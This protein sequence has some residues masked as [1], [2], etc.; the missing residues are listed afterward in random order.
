MRGIPEVN[1]ASNIE[2][3]NNIL[4]TFAN[5][6]D[7]FCAY[8]LAYY[9]GED[10]INKMDRNE[11]DLDKLTIEVDKYILLYERAAN[12]GSIEAM[13]YLSDLY[14]NPDMFLVYELKQKYRNAVK[15]IEWW[16]V[17]AEAG[18]DSYAFDLGQLYQKGRFG[19][20]AVRINIHEAIKWYACGAAYK[21]YNTRVKVVGDC[22]R[23]LGEIYLYGNAD[24]NLQR[25]E[26]QADQYFRKLFASKRTATN[27][28]ES[29]DQT[30]QV[31]CL[32]RLLNSC[33]PP[34]KLQIQKRFFLIYRMAQ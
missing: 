16:K 5:N 19:G 31:G 11:L 30:S 20:I 33:Y 24:F 32:A 34:N 2:E 18:Y 28:L 15:S 26:K 3:A 9:A 21:N 13:R 29:R 25:D 4:R 22:L 23:T 12:L 17:L 27:V 14:L 8:L 7:A 10:V 1:I 6:G